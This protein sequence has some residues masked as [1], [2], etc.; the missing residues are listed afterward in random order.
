[1]RGKNYFFKL[2]NLSLPRVPN[3]MGMKTGKVRRGV[4]FKLHQICYST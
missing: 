3:K 2:T 4:I 1:M